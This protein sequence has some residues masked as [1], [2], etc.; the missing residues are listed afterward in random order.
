[1]GERARDE[2][3]IRRKRLR[4]MPIQHI[5]ANLLDQYAL[6]TLSAE[7]IA[8][9]E[10]HLLVCS[11]CQNRLVEADEFLILFREAATPEDASTT[12]RWLNTFAFRTS[13]WSGAA[14]ALAALLI[15]LITG[16]SHHAN[17]QPAILLMQSL[18]GP[19]AGA[20]MGSARPFLLI[21]DVAV[22]ANPADYEIEI[23]DA[24]CNEVLDRGADVRDGRLAALVERLARGR[25][26]VRVYRKQPGRELLA[27]YSLRAE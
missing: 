4:D 19:E 8:E 18:R 22:Q 26:W 24:V 13:F 1:M 27:E 6:G 2:E 17:L 3:G 12:Q 21:F 10:E 14:A 16:D 5:E 7:S 15:L 25:Y 9:L 20:V 23:V 11:F